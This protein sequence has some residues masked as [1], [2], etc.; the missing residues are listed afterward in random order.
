MVVKDISQR[1]ILENANIRGEITRLQESYK[2]V[3]DNGDYPLVVQNLLGELISA[4]VLLSSTLKFEGQLSIQA[5]GDGYLQLI[6]AECRN[7]KRIRAI[8]QLDQNQAPPKQ[9]KPNLKQLLGKGQL[10]ITLQPDNGEQ[11]QGIVPLEHS[12]LATNI[13][14][15]FKRSEQ[16][17]TR[18]F[19][20]CQG[21]RAGGMLLQMLPQK[22]DQNIAQTETS[23]ER[24]C[25]LANT[26]TS[27]EL[28]AMP[29]ERMLY[30]L[31]NGD[32][33][34]LFNETP[35]SFD[36]RCNLERTQR[37][38]LALQADELK[39]ILDSNKPL[40]VQCQ[41]CGTRYEFSKQDIERFL[42]PP[43]QKSILH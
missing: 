15:Y 1:F 40:S 34:R 21:G 13:E 5:R 39:D 22:S 43:S 25:M 17:P 23:W 36:C 2:Q 26:L 6:M 31:Y 37:A 7:D 12:S 11:Y 41:F 33:V 9:G 29:S 27:E 19:L 4:A 16:I 28:L 10:A 42:N 30:R 20:F 24:A 35:V 18:L 32:E 38:L 3:L 14:H 8:A